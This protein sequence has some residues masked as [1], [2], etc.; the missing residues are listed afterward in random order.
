VLQAAHSAPTQVIAELKRSAKIMKLTVTVL[1]FAMACIV[2]A[3]KEGILEFSSFRLESAGIGSSGK[4][5]VE[6]KQDDQSRIV[7]LKVEAFGK[8]FDVSQ[9]KLAGLSGLSANG[10][11]IS[12][13][14]GYAQLG[15]RTIYIE[16]Q[17]GF[18]S[19]TRKQARVT[20]YESGAIEVTGIKIKN[21]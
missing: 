3:S 18:T 1:F 13:E 5:V 4:V 10:V 7:S 15:G 21:D 12:Y 8:I 11:R 20:I 2:H 6:G 16:L 14:Q 9:E 17:M 19:G